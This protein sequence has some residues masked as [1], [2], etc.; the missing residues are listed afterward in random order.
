MSKAIHDQTRRPRLQCATGSFPESVRAAVALGVAFV[1]LALAPASA[2]ANSVHLYQK[3]WDTPAGSQPSA[4]A[5][6]LAGNV[7][8]YNAGFKSVSKYDPD[9]NPVIFSALGTNS[10]D[11]KGGGDCPATPADCDR[12]PQGQLYM[13]FWTPTVAVDT[14]TGPTTG[15]IYVENAGSHF[16]NQF[17]QNGVTEVFAPTGQFLGEIKT[18]ADGPA[19]I[20]NADSSVNVDQHGSIYLND[21][22]GRTCRSSPGGRLGKCFRAGR[23]SPS[24]RRC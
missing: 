23:H 5:V 6:D 24:C 14:T 2:P 12:V 9:G 10:I 1:A 8:V 17:S 13:G 19:H 16:G 21:H 3:S 7:Y 18:N 11:G 22:Q 4:E 15:Y 20:N